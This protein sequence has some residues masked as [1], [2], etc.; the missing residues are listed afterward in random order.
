ME[1]VDKTSGL[2]CKYSFKRSGDWFGSWR[3][4]S[5]SNEAGYLAACG[6]IN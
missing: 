6:K 4:V 3:Q 1:G 5:V 2:K